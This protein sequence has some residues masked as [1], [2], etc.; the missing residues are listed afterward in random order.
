M[1]A[2]RDAKSREGVADEEVVPRL[3][4]RSSRRT[5]L[6]YARIREAIVSGSLAPGQQLVEATLAEW[7]GFSRTPVR[8]A[9]TRL[10][11]DGLA[12]RGD[13]GVIVRTRSVEEILDVYDIR[14]VLEAKAAA[15]AA[16]RRTTVDLWTMQQAAEQFQV[17]DRTDYA[18]MAET[19]KKFHRTVWVASHNEPLMGLLERLTLY[20]GRY[21]RTTLSVPGRYKQSQDQHR[22]LVLAIQSRNAKAAAKVATEHF[23]SARDRRLQLLHESE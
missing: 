17:C 1:T 13:S 19:N 10:V 16:E 11:Q 15:V 14:I 20:L 5:E 2:A 8:E 7:C 9:L 18:T 22:E 23:A 3:V 4:G 6:A 21:T 12:C